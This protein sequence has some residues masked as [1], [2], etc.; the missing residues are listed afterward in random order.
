VFYGDG[1]RKGICAEWYENGEEKK[2]NYMKTMTSRT[3][4]LGM[5]EE[6]KHNKGAAARR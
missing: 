5:K 2:K 1:V 3:L 6:M 4:E